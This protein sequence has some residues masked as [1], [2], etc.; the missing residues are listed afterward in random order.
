M[1]IL[2]N[3]LIILY[4]IRVYYRIISVR[5]PKAKSTPIYIVKD[6]ATEVRGQEC[7][8]EYYRNKDMGDQC[9]SKEFRAIRYKDHYFHHSSL[10][11]QY[12][13][14]NKQMVGEGNIKTDL[15]VL[16]LQQECTE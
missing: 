12:P 16:H 10:P 5:S 9:L 8:T 6:L 1:W 15:E 14:Y 7:R 3:I 11:Q 13:K 2:K 4:Q